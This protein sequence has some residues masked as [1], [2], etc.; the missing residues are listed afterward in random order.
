MIDIDELGHL[1]VF[2]GLATEDL[3][4]LAAAGDEHPFDEGDILFEQGKPADAWWVL[5]DGK[6]E[7][8]RRAGR[9]VS[10]VNVMDRPGV[11]AG[12]FRAWNDAAGYMATGRA[13]TSGRMF[14][15]P[16]EAFGAWTRSVFPLGA[17]IIAGVFQTV[18]SIEATASQRESL[19]ALG[20]L[21]AG[22]AHEI[23]NPASAAARDAEALEGISDAMLASLVR[24]AERSLTA[25]QFLALDALRREIEASPAAADPL[26]LA[27]RE[28]VLMEWLERHSVEG[29][30]RIA[31]ALATAGVEVEWCE[32][33]RGVLAGPTLEPGLTWVASAL[34]ATALLEEV[35]ESTSRVT[36]LV[37]AVKSYSQM[38]RASLQ[39][40]D[41]T[42][43]LESTLVMRQSRLR[44]GVVVERAFGQEVPRIEANPGE[45]NQVWT[46]L[47]DNA[48]DA[49][50][51]RG[52]LRLV[53]RGEDDGV[54]VEV[55]DSGP[56]MPAEVQAHAF[57]P[58]FTTKEVG[59]GTG[60]GLDISRRIVVEHHGGIIEIDSRP[61]ATVLRVRLPRRRPART[62]ERRPS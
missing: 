9:E 25:D 43:G 18:R 7:L 49:M 58:F 3:A 44:D 19:V 37:A 11:W 55:I 61:G 53:T 36:A 42:E 31:P 41:V 17:H 35:R 39:L 57:E 24:L 60:L 12:G 28:E 22:L 50:D 56:G 13:A 47:I 27:D 6:V 2:D 33:V 62:E 5:L 15:V 29:A 10:V 54:V 30:W 16:A 14:R 40:I 51:G 46:N 21:A 20:T 26:A 52:T 34:S 23:N 4:A 48:V 38:D 8:L 45:L 1:F 59:K 32:R